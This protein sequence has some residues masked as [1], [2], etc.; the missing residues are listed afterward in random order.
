MALIFIAEDDPASRELLTDMLT[1][2]GHDV[3][4]FPNGAEL[5]QAL[6]TII[7]EMVL[8]DIQMPVMDGISAVR[9][10]RARGLLRLPV[11]ALTA[12]AMAGERDRILSSG[13]DSYMTKPISMPDLRAKIDSAC[14][15]ARSLS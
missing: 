6:S 5:V 15:T 10:I 2:W 8:L 14:V 7:P 4:A 3:Q 13:F 9:H 12:F 11:F 1:L